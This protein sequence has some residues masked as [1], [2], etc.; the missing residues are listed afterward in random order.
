MG[1]DWGNPFSSL[2]SSSNSSTVSSIYELGTCDASRYGTSVFVTG[3][4]CYYSCYGSWQ[5]LCAVSSSSE[6]SSSSNFEPFP[7]FSSSSSFSPYLQLSSSSAISSSSAD[8][9]VSEIWNGKTKVPETTYRNGAYYM[10]ISTAEELAYFANQVTNKGDTLLNAILV[11]DIRLNPDN[12]VDAA[13]NLLVDASE[14]Y[15]WTPIGS[16]PLGTSYK[17]I[18]DGNGHVVSGVYVNNLSLER[19]GFFGTTY[20]AKIRNL[21]I[22]NSY[23]VGGTYSG[24]VIGRCNKDSVF[25]VYSRAYVKGKYAGGITGYQNNSSVITNSYFTGKV[26]GS[27]YSAGITGY[28]NSRTVSATY[29]TGTIRGAGTLC[30]ITCDSKS[31]GSYFVND[32]SVTLKEYGATSKSLYNMKS[33]AFADTLNANSTDDYWIYRSNRNGGLP[34]FEWVK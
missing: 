6:I 21:G 16:S 22:E 25:Q 14:L 12:I 4:N 34:T 19:A 9:T 7:L 23:I 1:N 17:G 33:Y 8:T 28:K 5:S 29:S 3:E 15:E 18:F 13:G 11:K 10:I 2:P 30:G 26:Y 31:T 20:G 24:G 27:S 32:A